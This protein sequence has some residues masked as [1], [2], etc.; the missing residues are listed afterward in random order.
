MDA[1]RS[2][3]DLIKSRRF[4]RHS[5][6]SA[7]RAH[8]QR[9]PA[10]WWQRHAGRRSA[11]RCPRQSGPH[12]TPS[13]PC[14]RWPGCRGR[15]RGA[16]HGLIAPLHGERRAIGATLGE[17]VD[18]DPA[19]FDVNQQHDEVRASGEGVCVRW[20][21]QFLFPLA[22]CGRLDARSLEEMGV[23]ALGYAAARLILSRT[24][25]RSLG[26]GRRV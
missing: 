20:L 7:T 1:A 10:S 9:S 4:A 8:G 15:R 18:V 13:G 16:E 25:K 12:R 2:G 5:H 19:Y 21:P 26:S 23:I 3:R 11:G 22:S 14:H 6:S 24:G 17:T